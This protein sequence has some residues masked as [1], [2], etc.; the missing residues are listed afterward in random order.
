MTFGS[1]APPGPYDSVW[2]TCVV[3][4]PTP[5][6]MLVTRVLAPSLRS[7]AMYWS[8]DEFDGLLLATKLPV[9]IVP[10]V[11][12]PLAFDMRS[13]PSI[14]RI[15]LL[16]LCPYVAASSK[17]CSTHWVPLLVYVRLKAVSVSFVIENRPSSI[18]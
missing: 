3:S 13:I 2:P 1:G 18:A 15:L 12:C 10:A 17:G 7:T 4:S 6:D 5:T 8:S 16:K 14:G 11:S 9:R